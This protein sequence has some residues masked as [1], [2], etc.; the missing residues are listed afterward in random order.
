MRGGKASGSNTVAI[1]YGQ[2]EIHGGRKL[3]V[4][5][6]NSVENDWR[7]CLR[8]MVNSP[9]GAFPLIIFEVDP[10]SGQ[11]FPKELPYSQL[12]DEFYRFCDG[13]Y[14]KDYRWFP[15]AELA[16][17]TARWQELLTDYDD[18]GNILIRGRHL[19]FAED[20]GGG[21][22]VWDAATDRVAS[23][24]W[25]GGDWE[26]IAESMEQFL[27]QLFNP[28]LDQP[29]WFEALKQLREAHRI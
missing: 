27:A 19:V 25:K 14:F 6:V 16:A 2:E 15:I 1:G 29:M 5:R 12:L 10:A 18:R 22:I 8:A 26:P 7:A 11:E 17:K 23:F 4:Q 20:S 28:S 3:Q 9:E 13:G 24:W 21:P